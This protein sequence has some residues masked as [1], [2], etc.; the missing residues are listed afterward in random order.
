MLAYKIKYP[1]NFFLLRGNH[2]CER[3]NRA[4]GFYDECKRRYN[5]QIW[6]TFNGCFNCL[7]LAAIIDERIF[8]CH[9]GLSPDLHSM[10]QIRKIVRPTVI[11]D[12]GLLCDLLWADP[13]EKIN[14][15]G[16]HCLSYTFGHEIV[17]R[18]LA[19]HDFNLVCCSNQV[20]KSGYEFFFSRQLVMLFSATN[21]WGGCGNAAA[22]MS[23]EESLMCS[24]QTSTVGFVPGQFVLLSAQVKT[25]P[26]SHPSSQLCS[27]PGLDPEGGGG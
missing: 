1:E 3:M 5:V 12:R 14:G 17:R 4:H 7:P 18:F 6:E 2:E 8:C 26:T 19:K 21:L 16:E 10:E 27:F 20:V 13:D 22:M 15:W 11:P 23:V 25:F 9:G 24:F